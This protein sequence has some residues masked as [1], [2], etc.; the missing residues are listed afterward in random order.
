M[1]QIDGP[2][3]RLGRCSRGRPVVIDRGG[4]EVRGGRPDV[5]AVGSGQ[6]LPS[7]TARCL[8]KHT[9]LL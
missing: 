6:R 1:Y 3:F 8:A 5:R 4:E 2:P 7:R 9:G